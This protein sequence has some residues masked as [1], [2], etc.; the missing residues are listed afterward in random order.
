[1]GET[2]TI[3]ADAPPSGKQF[4]RWQVLSF[5]V[6]LANS[7]SSTTTFIMPKRDVEV[8]ATYKDITE[9]HTHTITRVDAKDAT[10]TADGNKAYYHCEDC[11]K[12]YE[13]EAGT[14]LIE[15]ISAWGN[16]AAL[17]HDWGE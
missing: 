7:T 6:I 8:D 15:N 1:V 4:D 12:N 2:V 14:A 16:I 3:T 5:N 13:D 10:C 17:G 11:G 9:E